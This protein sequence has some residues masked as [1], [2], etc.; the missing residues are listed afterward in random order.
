MAAKAS[1]NDQR[2]HWLDMSR[3]W[4]SMADCISVLAGSPERQL[5]EAD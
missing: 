4:F 3:M 5:L 2:I 1:E